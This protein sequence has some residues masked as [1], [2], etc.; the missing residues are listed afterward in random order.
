VDRHAGFGGA[1]ESQRIRH[2]WGFGVELPK[3]RHPTRNLTLPG[4][5]RIRRML[6]ILG[7]SVDNP[8]EWQLPL[9]MPETKE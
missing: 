9:R 6:K 4:Q 2:C 8:L 5:T 3:L 1:A 7:I